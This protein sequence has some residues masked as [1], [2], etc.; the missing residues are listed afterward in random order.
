MIRAAIN[1]LYFIGINIEG[2][3]YL[4]FGIL[5]DRDYLFRETGNNTVLNSAV[6]P[7][8]YIPKTGKIIWK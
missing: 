1:D 2:F 7:G 3:A 5:R 8:Q 6:K 4:F